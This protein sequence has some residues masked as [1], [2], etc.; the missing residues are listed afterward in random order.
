M[1]HQ[2]KLHINFLKAFVGNNVTMTR[3][4]KIPDWYNKDSEYEELFN[5]E[6]PNSR[7]TNQ[8]IEK[9]LKK[10]NVKTVLDLTCGTGSQVFWLLKRGYKV[11]GSDI[12]PGML[13]IAKRKAKK[14]KIK[15]KFLRGDMRTIKVG[16]FDAVI[17]I[18]NAIGHLTKSG[19]EKTMRN[20][21]SNLNDGGIYVF[22]IINL[23]YVL[24]DDNI[25]KMSL[26]RVETL[27]N[28][29]FRE[30][31]HSI[32]DNSGILT[33]YTTFYT[34]KGTHKPEVSKNI[35]TLQLY[36]AEELTKM[37]AK[38]GFKV[39]GQYGIDGSKFNE[40]KTERILTIAKKQ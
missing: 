40:K 1:K 12:S 9:I 35:I 17:T 13:K 15:M 36:T 10:Y 3:H 30:L 27:D 8:T 22:D 21:H 24:Y 19:F 18:F 32:I 20:I 38:N 2:I 16:K 29:K 26:E 37:L 4:G 7:I 34:Q 25:T 23:N 28:I 11:T 5:E 31:Q 6:S 39:L 33:S 14:D